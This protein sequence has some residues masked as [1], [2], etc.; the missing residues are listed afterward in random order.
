MMTLLDDTGVGVQQTAAVQWQQW[1]TTMRVVV[2]V[3]HLLAAAEGIVRDVLDDVGRACD[4]FAATS[5]LNRLHRDLP[6]GVEVSDTLALLVRTAL[7]AARLTDGDV[8]PTLG[9]ALAD[10]GYDRDIAHL[11]YDRDTTAPGYDRDSAALGYDRDTTAAGYDRDATALGYDRESAA[12]PA[13]PAVPA[14]TTGLGAPAA[15]PSRTVLGV[16]V[17]TSTPRV[18]GWRRI[19]L[20]GNR[21]TVPADLSL[22]LGATAKALAADLA[23]ARVF[24]VLGSGVLVS[25]GGDIATAGPGPDG[26]WQITVCDLPG[27]PA[28]QVTLAPGHAL[29]TSSTQ[30]RRWQQGGRTLHHILD[31]ALGLPADAVWRTVT[32]SAASCVRANTVS[33]ASVVRGYRAIGWL[34]R[35]ATTAR[36]VNRDGRVLTLGGWPDDDSVHVRQAR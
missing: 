4:R 23:A 15:R 24:A 36:L 29:A 6:E 33:T 22:D 2:T 20:D 17:T 11:G 9:A 10:L 27:D 1:S 13:A 30:K 19:T 8:D 12:T 35:R 16:P 31:P 28:S 18:A 21:L 32:V 3:P 5:E 14:P 25:L 7:A 34:A 26:G